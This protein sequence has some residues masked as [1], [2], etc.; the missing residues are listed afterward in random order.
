MLVVEDEKVIAEVCRRT[1]EADYQVTLVPNGQAAMEML[2]SADFD[3]CL[4]DIRTPLMSGEELYLWIKDNK[5]SLLPG[6]IFT[7]GDVI[8]NYTEHFLQSTG[9]PYLPKPFSPKELLS[10]VEKVTT[11]L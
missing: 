6:V 5:P 10:T 2:A 7:T 9:L 4:I 11:A 1:L 8:S 3:I